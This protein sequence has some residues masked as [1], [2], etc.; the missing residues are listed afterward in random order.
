[1]VKKINDESAGKQKR[2]L[3]QLNLTEFSSICLIY[4]KWQFIV[5]IIM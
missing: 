1:M 2:I 3:G 4:G 5:N